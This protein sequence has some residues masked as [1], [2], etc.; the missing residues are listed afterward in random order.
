MIVTP[1][2]RR[3]RSDIERVRPRFK[4]RDGRTLRSRLMRPDDAS[5]LIDLF[6]SLSLESKRRRFHYAVDYTPRYLV[7]EEAERLATVDNLTTG[8]AVV[9]LEEVNGVERLVAVARLMRPP[10]D[11]DAEDVEAAIVVRDDYQGAG[12]AHELLRRMVL[13]ARR[14]RARTIVAEIEADNLSA[15]MAFRRLDLPTESRTTHGETTLRISVPYDE[16]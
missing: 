2:Q 7:L 8:G 15:I 11:P 13:L 10:D 12:V 5:K 1:V 3:Y 14:M 9:A 16:G 6:D 4:T